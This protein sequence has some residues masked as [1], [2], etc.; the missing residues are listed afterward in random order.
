[1]DVFDL[2]MTEEQYRELLEECKEELRALHN[3]ALVL[4]IK[5][6]I[7]ARKR[8]QCREKLEMIRMRWNGGDMSRFV[9]EVPEVNEDMTEHI[10]SDAAKILHRFRANYELRDELKSLVVASST[11]K[12]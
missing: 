2:T 1:M 10:L 7:N 6:R 3:E 9:K 8:R 12:K 5:K 11:S 4:R